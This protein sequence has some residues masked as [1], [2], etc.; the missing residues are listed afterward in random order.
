MNLCG[1]ASSRSPVPNPDGGSGFTL[2]EV[3]VALIVI[4]VGVATTYQT[5][6]SS[7]STLARLQ[8]RTLAGWVADNRI[9]NLQLG[10][11]KPTIGERTGITNLGHISWQW[12]QRIS[13]AADPSLRR[14]TITVYADGDTNSSA[15]MVAFIPAL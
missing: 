15:R 14:V 1:Q 6:A 12:V 5:L 8:N 7:A 13:V 3:L 11:T 4:S 9:S 2:L 10:V